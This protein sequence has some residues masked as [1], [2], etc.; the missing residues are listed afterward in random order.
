M[1]ADARQLDPEIAELFREV[2]GDR[3][4][5][6]F[7]PVGC[8]DVPGL[9]ALTEPIRATAVSRSKAE[10]HLIQVYRE[11]AAWLLLDAARSRSRT[12]PGSTLLTWFDARGERGPLASADWK[13]R[14]R[15][16]LREGPPESLSEFLRREALGGSSRAA[17]ALELAAASLRL[18]PTESA[19]IGVAVSMIHLGDLRRALKELN[20]ALASRPGAI[21]ESIALENIGTV[22][23]RQGDYT[24]A[25]RFYRRS[26]EASEP[27]PDS[28]MQLLALACLVEQPRDAL[29]AAE[30]LDELVHPEHPAI[31]EYREFLA[32][33][34]WAQSEAFLRGR[35]SLRERIGATARSLIA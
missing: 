13:R 4:A 8:G 6:L 19:R 28:M 30:L 27:R 10:R 18:V 14:A 35:R 22:M 2:A 33:R 3:K 9:A 15:N 11:E 25:V 29:F 5:R 32:R 21:L 17:S 24:R 34:R 20:Q 31:S 7:S 12:E 16:L 23:V 26:V 1:S